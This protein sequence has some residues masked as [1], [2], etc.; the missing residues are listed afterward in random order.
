MGSHTARCCQHDRVVAFEQREDITD[1]ASMAWKSLPHHRAVSR[2]WRKA[3]TVRA[4]RTTHSCRIR[5]PRASPDGQSPARRARRGVSRP[6]GAESLRGGGSPA[7][8]SW[9][10]LV[11]TSPSVAP[12]AELCTPS[13]RRPPCIFSPRGIVPRYRRVF[14]LAH[15]LAAALPEAVLSG[16]AA[17]RRFARC[18]VGQW[19]GAGGAVCEDHLT[20]LSR[21]NALQ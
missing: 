17:V 18:V 11:M 12:V 6:D 15:L 3:H 9:T 4:G 21:T 19:G 10:S 5:S 8:R 14:F 13:P 1:V 16:G 2:R 20:G 7:T